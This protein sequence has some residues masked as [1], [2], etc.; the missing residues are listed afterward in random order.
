MIDH[1]GLEITPAL[2]E[3]PDPIR[4]FVKLRGIVGSRKQVLEQQ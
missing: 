4:I 3:L 2:V 1:T